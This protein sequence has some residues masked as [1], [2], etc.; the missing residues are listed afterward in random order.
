MACAA[1]TITIDLERAAGVESE[2]P[3]GDSAEGGSAPRLLPRAST[4]V[5]MPEADVAKLLVGVTIRKRFIQYGAFDGVIL[6]FDDSPVC[7]TV[8]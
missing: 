8:L 2:G 3:V 1:P 4:W 6:S 7:R 5:G